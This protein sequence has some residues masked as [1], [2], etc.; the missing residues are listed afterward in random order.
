MRAA[1]FNPYL[2][3]LGGGER[4]TIS[5]ARVLADSGYD[6]FIEWKNPSI[7][8][9]LEDRF[10]IRLND[11]AFVKNVNKGEGFDLIFWVSDGSVPLLRAKKNYIHFQMPFTNVDGRSLI[12]RMKM[13]RVSK[14][15]CNSEFTKKFIDKEYAVNSVV[16]YPPVD[17]EKIIPRRKEN[18]ILY[19]GRFSQLAQSKNQHI[20]VE[21]FKKMIKR[22]LRG[23]K[24]VLAGGTE[25]G[26]EEYL[27]KL[28]RSS[29]RFPIEI[30]K[31]P[32]FEDLKLLYGKAKLFWS[33]TGFGIDEY[34][35]PKRVEHFGMTVVEAMSAKCVPV[36]F[37]AGG[38]R[39]IV[40]DGVN[41]FLWSQQMKIIKLSERLIASPS[42]LRKIA[43]AAHERAKSFSYEMF[44]K[45]VLEILG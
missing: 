20:L 10:G 29:R 33:A 19:V 2:D 7:I 27:K 36:I 43:I 23:W 17:V 26:A 16:L 12:N 42:F 35:N 32:S 13:F 3:T 40:Q 24:L 8:K 11:I 4:Y 45:K 28:E 31:S 14:V 44:S 15:I 41:G 39:E 34:R 6:V 9:S 38:Y 30:I 18:I 21:L 22:G 25:V 1:I 5:F 37:D